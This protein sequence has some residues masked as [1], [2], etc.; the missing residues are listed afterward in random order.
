MTF[1]HW[2]PESCS[3]SFWHQSSFHLLWYSSQSGFRASAKS[4]FLSVVIYTNLVKRTKLQSLAATCFK[5]SR[6][7]ACRTCSI[8]VRCSKVVVMIAPCYMTKK[9]KVSSTTTLTRISLRSMHS[10]NSRKKIQ[11][12][13][14]HSCILWIEKRRNTKNKDHLKFR[15]K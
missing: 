13:M 5:S 7:K 11:S 2:Q 14:I 3:G 6:M 1:N 10:R 8:K 4:T 9:F 15:H 12:S